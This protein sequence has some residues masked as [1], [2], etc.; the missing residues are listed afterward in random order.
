[1]VFV[2]FLGAVLASA[3]STLGYDYRAYDAAAR[4]VLSG[5]AL[6]SADVQVVGP[7]GEFLYPPTFALVL[8]PLVAILGPDPLVLVWTVALIAMF[9]IGIALMPVRP[10]TRWAILVLAGLMWPFLYAV[11]LGEVGPILFL[12]FAI[13]WRSLERDA[14][15]G[16]SIAVGALIKL[17]PGVALL[18]AAL[19]M[20]WRVVLAAAAI[21]VVVALAATLVAGL[22]AW[23]D[24]LRLLGQ[25]SRP[26]TTPPNFSVGAIALRSGAD[27]ATA[28]VLQY[29]SSLAALAAL[30]YASL[31]RSPVV[32]YLSA[33]VVSQLLS[34]VLWQHYA[35]V[36]LLP[37]AWLLDRG[38]WWIALI[39]V[40][41][42]LPLVDLAP[43]IFYPVSFFVVLA[44]VIATAAGRPRRSRLTEPASE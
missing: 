31:R 38:R 21:G 36:L 41:L 10:A 37:I 9:L 33:V 26:S 15:L 29:A 27:T 17:Q 22:D 43:P 7:G 3:G 44:G 16:S 20:R 19:L 13:G 34:P 4:R 5:E 8:L 28:T 6:Y 40:A 14:I 12:L 39:P 32:G 42:S 2:A 24:F 35:V 23:G 25:I 18:W 1:V 11:K 30:V